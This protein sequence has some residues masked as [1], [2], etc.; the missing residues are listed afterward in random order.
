MT[1]API[2]LFVFN[3]PDHTLQVLNSLEQNALAAS[4]LLYIISDGKKPGM[5]DAEKE[6]IDKVRQVIRSRQWCGE[7][8]IR[9][10]ELNEGLA[11]SIISAVTELLDKHGKLIVLEDDLVLSPHALH[12]FN[13]SLNRFE[14]NQ[15]IS[16][17]HGYSFPANY[18]AGYFF[19][20]GAD[21]WGWATWKDRWQ[22]FNPDGKALA[23]ELEAKGLV[24]EF[25]FYGTYGFFKMLK[26]QSEGR[27]NSWAIRWYASA[28]LKNKLTLYPKVPFTVNSG[29]DG[30]GYHTRTSSTVYDNVLAEAFKPEELEQ[31]AVEESKA[32]KLETARFFARNFLGRKKNFIFNL[33]RIFIS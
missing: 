2:V 24:D 11:G 18:G 19:M 12:Y 10:K 15:E 9:E 31:I 20:K 16:C 29:N 33:R 30:S 5:K 21:C 23:S 27:N 3:R 22:D 17:I 7:V 32:R 14:K 6:N 28:F 4:S 1:N 13:F 25:D 26:D 8:I